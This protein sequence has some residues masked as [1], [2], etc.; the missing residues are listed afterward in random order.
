MAQIATEVVP[1][2]L[3]VVDK[4]VLTTVLATVKLDVI[5]SALLVVENLVLFIAVLIVLVDVQDVHLVVMRYVSQV[6][7]LH[8]L[9]AD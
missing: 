1:D 5:L 3:L 7:G 2:V 8:V 6:A 9:D 4:I